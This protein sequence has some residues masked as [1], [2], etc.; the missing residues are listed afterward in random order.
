MNAEI[1]KEIE[2]L[3]EKT[4]AAGETHAAFIL[5]ILC[6]A[7]QRGETME[8]ADAVG[9]FVKTAVFEETIRKLK[10]HAEESKRDQS[11]FSDN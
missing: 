6:G 7:L 5:G 2:K 4:L 8:L 1:A 11:R 3:A 9:D 10:E